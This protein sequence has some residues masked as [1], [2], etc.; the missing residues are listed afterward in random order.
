MYCRKKIREGCWGGILL[1]KELEKTPLKKMRLM[2]D[3]KEVNYVATWG[4]SIPENG[5][6][7]TWATRQACAGMNREQQ[8]GFLG[9]EYKELGGE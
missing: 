6:V 9:L 7:S 5:I 2:K 1:D 4:R 3:E 8:E